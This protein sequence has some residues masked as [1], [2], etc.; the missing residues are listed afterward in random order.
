LLKNA[1]DFAS[2]PSF[3][4]FP[5]AS[6]HFHSQ[7]YPASVASLEKRFEM[8][9]TNDL[10]LISS[11]EFG[12]RRTFYFREREVPTGNC[13][14]HFSGIFYQALRRDLTNLRVL[15]ITGV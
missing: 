9:S 2:F 5:Q 4:T 12:G 7:Q 3:T 11:L 13:D 10:A 1:Y 6:I 15:I 14:C 8:A